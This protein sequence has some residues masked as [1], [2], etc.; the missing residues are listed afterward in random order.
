MDRRRARTRSS[1]PACSRRG[2]CPDRHQ[3]ALRGA[4]DQLAARR[5]VR[6]AAL[7]LRIVRADGARSPSAAPPPAISLKAMIT[8]LVPLAIGYL[9]AAFTNRKRALHDIHGRHARDKDVLTTSAGDRHAQR[10]EFRSPPRRLHRSGMPSRRQAGDS[11]YGGFWLRVVAYI[12]DAILLG[13]RLAGHCSV[14]PSPQPSPGNRG[15][16]SGI[17]RLT[18]C[19]PARCS[20]ARRRLGLLRAPGKFVGAGHAGQAAGRHAASST[21]TRPAA[22][23]LARLTIRTWPL[24][25]N[26]RLNC[27]C[28]AR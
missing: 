23:A 24:Y 7:G 21:D 1:S 12:V 27:R 9:M 15:G 20:S 13:D 4:D 16:L 2:R 11:R 25:L 14:L 6:Q 28:L 19:R 22:C 26:T 17:H 5:H 10:S 18:A 3:L 8:P